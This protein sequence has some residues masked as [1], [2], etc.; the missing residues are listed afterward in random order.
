M[1]GL[2]GVA[3]AVCAS[4]SAQPA[5]AYVERAGGLAF[6]KSDPRLNPLHD[7]PRFQSLVRRLNFP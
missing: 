6:L 3:V 7:D 4:T 2:V 5:R 1:C